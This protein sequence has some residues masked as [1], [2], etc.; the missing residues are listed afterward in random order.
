MP[1]RIYRIA[2]V[3]DT[4]E[5]EILGVQ[6]LIIKISKYFNFK[7]EYILC[8]LQLTKVSSVKF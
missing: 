2:H 3:A 6:K 4:R 8:G 7:E 5:P 1:W